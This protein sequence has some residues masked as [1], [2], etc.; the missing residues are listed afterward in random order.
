L[1]VI[2]VTIDSGCLTDST[3]PGTASRPKAALNDNIGQWRRTLKPD[4]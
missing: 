4:T 3:A 2:T 1:R